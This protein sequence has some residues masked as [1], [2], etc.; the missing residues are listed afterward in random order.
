VLQDVICFQK[1]S[2]G[3]F[4]KDKATAVL[5]YRY[6]DS[7]R[8]HEGIVEMQEAGNNKETSRTMATDWSEF[9]KSRLGECRGGLQSVFGTSG[10][11]SFD[12]GR[13][14]G[15]VGSGNG[16]R[17]ALTAGSVWRP[18]RQMV[19]THI[20]VFFIIEQKVG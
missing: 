15:F 1:P 11:Q 13:S 16:M 18:C 19:C 7:S 8:A 17:L 9:R 20:F 10:C 3:I 5:H 12:E 14:K 6:Y 2:S 4:V